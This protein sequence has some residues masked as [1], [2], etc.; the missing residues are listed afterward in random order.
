MAQNEIGYGSI[1]TLIHFSHTF[2]FSR[3]SRS[4][5]LVAIFP[6]FQADAHGNRC[7]TFT[8]LP[9]AFSGGRETGAGAGSAGHTLHVPVIFPGKSVDA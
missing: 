7:T 5:Q 6:V 1:G 8:K 4:K 3:H 2:G 9:V